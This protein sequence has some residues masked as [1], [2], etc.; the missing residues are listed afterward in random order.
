MEMSKSHD[1]VFFSTPE[2][3]EIFSAR[4]Q[5]RAMM[6]FEWA[7]SC[8][9]EKAGIAEPGSGSALEALLDAEFVDAD[10]LQREAVDAGNIAIPFVQ[11]LTAK[12]SERNAA[13][14]RTIHLGATSQDVLDTAL[15]LQ[16]R[17]GLRLIRA[18]MDRMNEALARRVRAHSGTIMTGR[19]WLQAGPPT[20]LGLKLAGTISALKRHR[21]RL[22]EASERA[23]VLQFGGAVG[24]LASLGSQ[25]GRV[26]AELARL[27]QLKEPELP[28]QTQR[29][30][31][32]EVAQ[33][34]AL[35]VG[36]LGK[37]ARDVALLMQTEVGEASEPVKEGRGG[38]ST[39]PHKHNPVSCAAVLAAAARIPGLVS[40]LLYAMPQ[41]HERG[42]GLWQAEWET[43]PEIF[44][45]A[46][47]ALSRSIE[48]AEGLEVDASRMRDNFEALQGLTMSEAVS[49]ALVQ[50]VGRAAAHELVRRATLQAAAERRSL[51]AVLQESPEVTAHLKANEIQRLLEPE[52]YLG[53]A[54]R[55]I[56]RVLRG[57]DA[58]R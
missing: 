45:L 11:Q 32:V 15:V 9:L 27:L 55:F 19:T 21:V 6:R 2:M 47:A 16:M 1:S 51:A 18:A 20:T 31:L 4:G 26:S 40:T 53:S 58:D 7:L 41:E 54:Q 24:T 35:A 56:D 50:K 49:T 43:I 23:L 10:A 42:L 52:S 3:N 38:S 36:T 57:P 34:L 30:S 13:A 12:V 14:A 46:G 25:G 39:M 5:L 33:V 48:V 37:F 28:W 8:A 29:D 17:E 44:C 22:E